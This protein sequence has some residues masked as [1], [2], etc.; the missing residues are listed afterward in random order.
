MR[1]FFIISCLCLGAGSIYAI[2]ASIFEVRKIFSFRRQFL[3]AK[4]SSCFQPIATKIPDVLDRETWAHFE[5]NLENL[6]Q[7]IVVADIVQR[8]QDSLL[9]A[10]IKNFQRKVEYTFLV[11]A[12]NAG[13]ALHGYVEVFQALAQAAIKQHDLD[14]KVDDLVNIEALPDE[15]NGVPFVFYRLNSN[16]NS[17]ATGRRT[18]AFFGNRINAGIAD[19]YQSLPPEVADALATALVSGAPRPI[20]EKLNSV[21]NDIFFNP[22]TLILESQR[23]LTRSHN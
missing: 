18:L 16:N 1:T 2:V 17:S 9:E 5:G 19:C 4:A 12:S 22:S 10:V 8:P 3:Q 15:W 14:C 13:T 20:V 23:R 7:V 21:E 11:S 6:T